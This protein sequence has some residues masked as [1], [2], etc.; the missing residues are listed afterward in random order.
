MRRHACTKSTI[1]HL[2]QIVHADIFAILKLSKSINPILVCWG[3]GVN[4]AEAA[5]RERERE[6]ERERGGVMGGW[7]GDRGLIVDFEN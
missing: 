2:F 4:Y 7:V 5:M 3:K 1:R 6:R